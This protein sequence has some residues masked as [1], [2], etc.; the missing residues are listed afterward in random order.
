MVCA[1]S[2]SVSGCGIGG[3]FEARAETAES[4]KILP[5]GLV[6]EQFDGMGSGSQPLPGLA[7]RA[8][9]PEGEPQP[10]KRVCQDDLLAFIAKV[11][12]H[13]AGHRRR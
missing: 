9:W 13:P 10:R 5:D 8:V 6:L 3:G 1:V 11:E 12:I 7:L 4:W 2:S